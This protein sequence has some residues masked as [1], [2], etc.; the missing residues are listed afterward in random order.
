M[1][2]RSIHPELGSGSRPPIVVDGTS[3]AIN[4][5]NSS[6]RFH[7][8]PETGD[9]T[10][11]HFGGPVTENPI[12]EIR[13]NG[14]GWSTVEHLRREWPDLGRG[15]FR[16]PA[17]HVKHAEGYTVSDFRYESHSVVEGKPDLPGLPSTFGS[18]GEVSTLV[19]HM[20]D[21]VSSVRADLSYSI[22][23][24]YDAIARSIKI[25]NEGTSDISIEKLASY[26]VDLPYEEYE[27]LQLHGEWTRECTRIRRKVDYGVQGYG[28]A[29]GFSSF[30]HN[31]FLALVSPST[32]ESHGNVWG[33]SL[34]Y[35][36]S[37]SVEVEK[38]PQGFTRALVGMNPIHLS[39]PLKP[40]E[41]FTSPECVSVFS[42]FGIGDMSRKFHR[43][44]RQ[45]LILSPFVNKPRPSL[46]NSWEGLYFN[47]DEEKIY[48]LAQDTAA[49]GVK[50]FV[51]DDGW[52]GV[53]YPRLNDRAALG[54]WDPNPVR[55]PNG[56]D[57]LADRINKLKVEN[58]S[59]SQGPAE[60]LQFGLWFEP[61]AV[62]VKSLL[63]EQHPEWVLSAG[64]YPRTEARNQLM[65]NLAL[66]EVQEFV[67]ESVSKILSTV[68]VTYL[69]WDANRAI[70]E[71][72]SPENHH[73]YILGFY[74]VSKVLTT[75]FP[76]VLWEGCASG[77]ARF[78]P[79]VLQYFPQFWTSDNTD[80]LSRIHIQFGTSLVYPPSTM[81]AHI[82]DVPNHY[83]RRT[84]P[85]RFRAHVAMM[86]GSFGLELNPSAI[87]PEDRAALPELISIAER[88]AP[89]VIEGDF[90]RLNLP[91][92]SNYPAAMFI[93]EDGSRAVLFYF[94]IR[95][96]EV[97]NF[98]MLYLQGLDETAFYRIDGEGAYSGATL[99]NGGIQKRF[100][101]DYDSRIYF[102]EKL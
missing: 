13:A 70:H 42:K 17:V 54:D 4:G 10:S 90:W 29:S 97:H 47:Y 8:D 99:M 18:E 22:F 61:E 11:D 31:P 41:S 46:L 94:Q 37:F 95:N 58:V 81:G 16:T 35:T 59:G 74:R 98:P 50:L 2:R 40:G 93:S 21:K 65:L 9:L 44:Y 89:I 20:V 75:R 36:G 76:H 102:I 6:Y 84:I 49:L 92:D 63:Y 57:S 51:L 67:I 52:F 96:T 78:D 48:K 12:A 71:S 82:S 30:Y 27:M 14:G 19:I 68:A 62:N 101:G 32:T 5:A 23:P 69:K 85:M 77:G 1:T 7:V 91:E 88:V 56:L 60:N 38:T 79:G 80:A 100:K 33:F 66:P 25:T 3:F 87:T 72:P 26:S 53:K 73:A 34:V 15:D 55:F 39:W 24:K 86:G 43:L 45:N 83:T 64:K 28:S